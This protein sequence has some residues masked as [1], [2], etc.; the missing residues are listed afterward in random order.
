MNY[1]SKRSLIAFVLVIL[2]IYLIK[3]SISYNVDGFTTPSHHPPTHLKN[4]HHPP[5]HLKNTHHPPTHLK[6][7]HHP[8]THLKNTHHPPTHLKNT[9]R[10]LPHTAGHKLTSYQT[11]A[12]RTTPK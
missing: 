7:T 4:T 6:N 3:F 12:P 2:T 9:Q 1:P 8:P 11:T 10:P 5:T